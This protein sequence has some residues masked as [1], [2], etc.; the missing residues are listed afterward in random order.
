MSA[1]TAHPCGGLQLPRA[2]ARK[3]ACP[4]SAL[5]LGVTRVAPSK[6]KT[7]KS[8]HAQTAWPCDV[9]VS[10]KRQRALKGLAACMAASNSQPLQCS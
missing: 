10:A 4:C 5:A 7:L 1:G 6:L 8:K 9:L 2:P 3:D